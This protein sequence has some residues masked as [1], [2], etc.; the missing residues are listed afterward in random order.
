[1]AAAFNLT[2]QLNLKG[3]TNIG[4]ITSSIKQQLG[5]ITANVDLKINQSSIKNV[6]QLNAGLQQLNKTLSSTT[7][8]AAS[9]AQALTALG[10][11]VGSINIKNLPQQLTAS[12]NAINQIHTESNNAKKE[13]AQATTQMEEFGKQ[14]AL[15]VRRFAAFSIVTSS[16]Y[17]LSNSINKG[18][19]AFIE[20]DQ[21]FVKLQQVTGQSANG[22]KSLSQEITSLSVGLGVSSSAL[23]DVAST[24]AQAGL[25]AQD[26]EKALRAL[27]L[28][29]LAPSFD[30]MNETVEGSIA[31][32][33]QFGIDA[34][35]LEKALSSINTVAAKFAVE[36][37]DIITAIQRTGGVFATASK[38][39]SEGTDALNEFIA[40]F[41]SV[42]ATTR[43]SAETIATGLRTIF[44]R[45]QRGSTI[46]ALKEFGVNLQDAEGKFVGAY[47]AVELLSKGLNSLDP[48][49]VKFSKIIEELGGFR[50]IG[51][52]IPLIQ[53]FSV[54]QNALKVAQQGQGS[55]AK[56]AATAQ[57]SLANQI[58]KV[59]Q[60]FLALFREIGQ[61]Q[62]F[63]VMVKATL[64]L[65]S[66]L[67]K[68]AD[69]SKGLLP[70]LGV[71][72][73]FKGASAITQ[74]ASGFGQGLKPG[75]GKK[76]QEKPLFSQGGPVRAFASGGVVP[77][78]GDG[79][80]VPAMLTPGEFVIRKKAV[81]A[82]GAQNL[83]KMNKY[84]KGGPVTLERVSQFSS[85]KQIPSYINRYSKVLQ[86]QDEIEGEI[87][88]RTI[89][90]QE[91]EQYYE[92]NPHKQFS[93]YIQKR[94][95]VYNSRKKSTIKQAG[96][97]AF[98]D[99][100]GEYIS[101]KD[102]LSGY[103]KTKDPQ[104]PVDFVGGDDP[105]EVRFRQSIT[106]DETILAKRFRHG[107]RYST[108]KM[109]G[110]FT[111]KIDDRPPVDIG[112][113]IVYQV[114]PSYKKAMGFALGGK[115]QKFLKGGTVEETAQLENMSLQDAILAQIKEMG[116]IKGVKSL[117]GIPGGQRTLDSLLRAEV[118][119]KRDTLDPTALKAVNDALSNEEGKT[120]RRAQNINKSQKL[121]V[122][123][124]QPFDKSTEIP[125]DIPGFES[126]TIFIRGLSSKYADAVA[127]MREMVENTIEKFGADIQNTMIFGGNAPLALDF[128]ETLVHGADIFGPNGKPDIPSYDD[129]DKVAKALNGD[130]VKLTPLG[131]K[132]KD[133]VGFD[134][135]FINRIRVLTARPQSNAGL[136]SQKLNEL[137]IPLGADKITGVSGGNKGT[138][139]GL[140]E[141]LVD[142]N[143]KNINDAKKA[144]KSAVQ[145]AELR[146]LSEEE[147]AATGNANAEGAILEAALAKMGAVG[148]SVQNRAVDFENGLGM[149]AAQAFPG[150][151]PDWPTEV[152]RTL[153]SDNIGRAKEEFKRYYSENYGPWPQQEEA[154]GFDKA[155]MPVS[156]FS[157][158]GKA[159]RTVDYEAGV[160][161]SPFGGSISKRL[162]QYVYGLQKGT[163]LSDQEFNEIKKTADTYGY[164]EQEFKEY[165]AKR[166]QEK[167]NRSG[168]R[169]DPSELLRQLTPQSRTSTPKQ[170]ALA[171]QLKGEPDAGYRPLLTQAQ[172]I[173][174]SRSDLKNAMGYAAGGV[175]EPEQK[176][177]KQYGKISISE[178]GTMISAGY[179]KN[180]SRQGYATAYKM[181][182]NL[183]YVGLSSATNGY[184]PRLYDIL[185]EAATEKGAMLTSDRSAVSGDA[186]K[187]W[188]YY[189]KNR[190][191][192]KKTPL[193]P[194]DWT[195]NDAL[196]DPKLH[197]RE[198]TWPPATDPAWVL[199]SG[200]SKNPN[201]INDKDV[202]R[203]NA[204]LDSRA[205]MNS[206][207][208]AKRQGFASGG[209]VEDTVPA[210][211]TP[212]E[213]VVNKQAAQRIGYTKLHQL[214]HADKIAGFNKGGIVGGIQGYA[215]GGSVIVNRAIEDL[216]DL[217]GYIAKGMR[218]PSVSNPPKLVTRPD[219]PSRATLQVSDK[220]AETVKII[221]Q[222]LNNLGVNVSNVA[223]LMKIGGDISYKAMEKAIK[224]DIERMTITGASIEQITKA[225]TA[226]AAVREESSTRVKKTQTLEDSFRN[227]NIGQKLGSGGSQ[228]QIITEAA[229]AEKSIKAQKI[230]DIS[231]TLQMPG[232]TPE[233]VKKRAT[234]LATTP[235]EKAKTKEL[236]Y[237]SAAQK[238]TGVKKTDFQAAGISGEDIQKY[239]NESLRD[240]KTLAVMDKQLIASKMQE[241]QSSQ[242]YKAA[243]NA[244]QSRMLADVKKAAQEEVSIRREII[245]DLAR[246]KGEKGV[247]AGGFMDTRNSPIYQTIK[248]NM[249]KT[250]GQG[251]GMATAAGAV[252]GGLASSYGNTI[253]NSFY[254]T[255]T[256][257]GK[258]KAAKTGAVISGTGTIASTGLG[259]AAQSL[260]VDPSGI[261]AGVIAAGTGLVAFADYM[262][263]FTGAQQKAVKEVEKAL[264]ARE[265]NA[266]TASLDD[267]FK[268]FE[269]D[270]S[271][272]DFQ[273]A[274]NKEL[275]NAVMTQAKDTSANIDTAKQD[276]AYQNRSWGDLLN[277]N[278]KGSAQMDAKQLAEVNRAEAEKF[279]PIADKGYKQIQAEINSGASIEQIMSN[280]KL[281]GARRAIAMS[282]PEGISEYT[283]AKA[284]EEK[285]T[286]KPITVNRNKEIIDEI[287]ARKIAT[288][289][290]ILTAI[291]AK[292]VADALEAANLAGRKL[293]QSFQRMYDSI[294]QAIN[295][296]NF[297]IQQRKTSIDYSTG[298]LTGNITTPEFASKSVD[299]LN[300]PKTYSKKAFEEA[301]DVA[302]QS[303]P[304]ADAKMVK[305]SSILERDLVPAIEAELRKNLSTDAGLTVDKAAETAKKTGTEQVKALGLPK[306]MEDTIIN[307]LTSSID[308]KAK[309]KGI[310]QEFANGPKAA[311]D[312][313]IESIREESKSIIQDAGGGIEKSKSLLTNTQDYLNDF[314]KNLAKSSVL[315]KQHA[316]SLIKARNI[317]DDAK[318]NLREAL[319]GIGET[320]AE[321]K[322]RFDSEISDLTGGTTDPKAI[323]ANIENLQNRGKGLVEQIGNST[324]N[325]D[326]IKFREELDQTNNS[327]RDN[328][329]ALERLA[330]SSELAAKALGEVTKVR[331]LQKNR[332]EL[333]NK[334]LTQTPEEAKKLNDTFVRLQNNLRGGLNNATNSRE[335]RAAFS[336]AL[337][338]GSSIQGAYRA[339]NTVLAQQ[340]Q[341]TLS[342]FQD[343]NI[344]GAQKLEMKNQA[345]RQGK[346]LSDEQIEN[347][348]N[349]QEAQLKT[350][351]AIETGQINNPMVRADI[352]AT[353]NRTFDPAMKQATD[354]YTK[355]TGRQA[356][357]NTE[358]GRLALVNARLINS[359]SQLIEAIDGLTV[360]IRNA[361][362]F[363]AKVEGGKLGAAAAVAA[364]KGVSLEGVAPAGGNAPGTLYASTGALVNFQPKGTDTVPAMLTPG[365]FV[366]NR[367]ST[368]QYLPLLQAINKSKGGVVYLAEGS[369]KPVSVLNR[370]KSGYKSF[371][372]FFGAAE[373]G[374]EIASERASFSTPNKVRE[375]AVSAMDTA[376]YAMGT[377]GKGIPGWS[378]I[379]S[380]MDATTKTYEAL[381]DSEATASEKALK[382]GGAFNSGLSVT[383]DLAV[384]RAAMPAVTPA[385]AGVLAPKIAS[386]ASKF[387][388]PLGTVLTAGMGVQDALNDKRANAQDLTIAEKVLYGITT[389]SAGTGGDGF[390][391]D[392]AEY[393]TSN[394][395][396][397]ASMSLASSP[398]GTAGGLLGY[399]GTNTEN[400]QEQLEQGTSAA[401]AAASVAYLGP[402]ATTAAGAVGGAAVTAKVA[403]QTARLMEKNRAD[404][405]DIMKKE[406][407]LDTRRFNEQMAEVAGPNAQLN[408]MFSGKGRTY[409]R[410]GLVY[411]AEGS[412]EPVKREPVK[413]EPEERTIET[414]NEFPAEV[415]ADR[416]NPKGHFGIAAIGSFLAK[417]PEMGFGEMVD[418]IF[419]TPGQG[420]RQGE[421]A[422]SPPVAATQAPAKQE[423]Q[424]EA[425][426]S[427]AGMLQIDLSKSDTSVSMPP[428]VQSQSGVAPV[429][430]PQMIIPSVETQAPAKTQA[431]TSAVVPKGA[432]DLLQDQY[433]SGVFNSPLGET[434]AKNSGE[435]ARQDLAK[436]GALNGSFIEEASLAM[437]GEQ[438]KLQQMTQERMS[439]SQFG[440]GRRGFKNRRDMMSYQYGMRNYG[441]PMTPDEVAYDTQQGQLARLNPEARKRMT[442]SLAS[443]GKL[444]QPGSELQ[445]QVVKTQQMQQ[446]MA[447][448]SATQEMEKL[449]GTPSSGSAELANSLINMANGEQQKASSFGRK[450]S[451]R[452]DSLTRLRDM[453]SEKFDEQKA[454]ELAGL[455]VMRQSAR[456]AS[457]PGL[458]K[459]QQDNR[460]RSRRMSLMGMSPAERDAKDQEDRT[461]GKLTY[462]NKSRNDIYKELRDKKNPPKEELAQAEPAATNAAQA[463]Q[464]ALEQKA[465]QNATKSITDPAKEKPVVAQAQDTAK[466]EQVV[467]QSSDSL[468]LPE[469]A[470]FSPVAK[471]LS[472][473]NEELRQAALSSAAEQE[474]QAT[475]TAKAAA[476]EQERQAAN[477]E[478]RTKAV[479]AYN[480]QMAERNKT[481]IY[482]ANKELDKLR[483]QDGKSG[484]FGKYDHSEKIAELEAKVRNNFMDTDD[485][486]T[487]ATLSTME[488]DAKKSKDNP[489]KLIADAR[490][491]THRDQE[492]KQLADAQ[493]KAQTQAAEDSKMWV[494]SSNPLV[495][496]L[497]YLGGVGQATGDMAYGAA[498][499]VAGTAVAGAGLI[500][501]GID[502]V[503]TSKEEARAAMLDEKIKAKQKENTQFLGVDLATAQ[504]GVAYKGPTAAQAFTQV[505]AEAVAQGAY[506]AVEG[507]QAVAGQGPHQTGEKSWLHQGDDKRVE[508]AG[509]YGG[510]TRAAQNIG[511]VSSQ[512]AV[513]L[514]GAGPGTA[515][516]GALGTTARVLSKIDDAAMMPLKLLGKGAGKVTSA[517]GNTRLGGQ[518][519]SM[520]RRAGSAIMDTPLVRGTRTV[521]GG[522]TDTVK[523]FD[524]RLSKI[525]RDFIKKNMDAA[526]GVRS[527][528]DEYFDAARQT[529]ARGKLS[530]EA[531]MKYHSTEIGAKANQMIGTDT[532]RMN[533]YGRLTGGDATQASGMLS[534]RAT[535]LADL[536]AARAAGTK[537]AA[538]TA[539]VEGR[540]TAD[541]FKQLDAQ[542][543]ADQVAYGN[544][545][546][547]QARRNDPSR[548]A[549]RDRMRAEGLATQKRVQRGLKRQEQ[550]ATMTPEQ[551]AYERTKR[552]GLERGVDIDLPRR[553][554]AQMRKTDE[555]WLRIEIVKEDDKAKGLFTQHSYGRG[556]SAQA[557]KA[558]DRLRR[559]ASSRGVNAD[560]ARAGSP[561]SFGRLQDAQ[562][563][564][565]QAAQVADMRRTFGIDPQ[566]GRYIDR[567]RVSTPTAGTAD[568]WRP[569]W[570]EPFRSGPSSPTSRVMGVMD[571]QPKT[572]AQ[573][574]LATTKK[575]AGDIFGTL[576]PEQQAAQRVI[577][578]QLELTAKG[579][580]PNTG[581]KYGAVSPKAPA[582]VPAPDRLGGR[583]YTMTA[584]TFV[585]EDNLVAAAQNAKKSQAAAKATSS[586][587][588]PHFM[589]K[590][591]IITQVAAAKKANPHAQTIGGPIKIAPPRGSSGATGLTKTQ[592]Q[593]MEYT[594]KMPGN[595]R[596]AFEALAQSASSPEAQ[597]KLLDDLIAHAARTNLEWI[598]NTITAPQMI[599]DRAKK[600]SLA[601]GKRANGL[602][603]YGGKGKP[604]QIIVGNAGTTGEFGVGVHESAHFLQHMSGNVG[605]KK[606]G[607]LI[608]GMQKATG[609]D[610]DSFLQTDYS[611][612]S[613]GITGYTANDIR[614]NPH[615]LLTVLQQARVDPRS[616]KAFKSSSKAQQLLSYMM[617]AHGYND[618]GIVYAANGALMSAMSKGTDTVP[619]MLTPGEFVMN[620]E[621]T[622][623]NLPLLKAI[624]S[625]NYEHGGLIKYMAQGGVV[626]PQYKAAGGEAMQQY[627]S[628]SNNS[629]NKNHSEDSRLERIEKSMDKFIGIATTFERA[630]ESMGNN[631]NQFSQ[632]VTT[633][634]TQMSHVLSATV[635]GSI[636]NS[637]GANTQI[638]NSRHEA[639]IAVDNNNQR[640]DRASEGSFSRSDPTIMRGT[641][642]AGSSHA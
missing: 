594:R 222:E 40:V 378:T 295:K 490:V 361:R 436:T 128:D 544:Y 299:V 80:T 325:D 187:V 451:M 620:R 639:Q 574:K 185:M 293:A 206:F 432:L 17:A 642:G 394:S 510:L 506:T 423:A 139:M 164:N 226:L 495:S 530:P 318:M 406:E 42:R 96:G 253:A 118:I 617:Q 573:V 250:F 415:A 500:A 428:V 623:Q 386:T 35:G 629:S 442:D 177:E 419:G 538:I 213:F 91:I 484:W 625:G 294:D 385:A 410:G 522:V 546:A 160:G 475:Q 427:S 374:S 491:K 271:N 478:A 354:E 367:E 331:D 485:A 192:V 634:P 298:A 641:P 387:T 190:G 227:S 287:A 505:G 85:G 116:G 26:T 520:A 28:S 109:L 203:Q 598:D 552:R 321:A 282:T 340:R 585:P 151:A 314:S 5:T 275:S 119:K 534:D 33:R 480:A 202:I 472:A 273:E 612:I 141:R 93:D 252:V 414:A 488:V 519:A 444:L 149:A 517:L 489:Y 52:V 511:Y 254:N 636:S 467:Q 446:T 375:F 276:Y 550:F 215:S 207:F 36:A 590:D 43:E 69:A 272:I 631:V 370:V 281:G 216:E 441:V 578:R 593:V 90:R 89:G 264:R 547:A 147:R 557:D 209:S 302:T 305:G 30:S 86:N 556:A 380:A 365:E 122:V 496:G 377:A 535:R 587:T 317:I 121:A 265:I 55:L 553:Q 72:L 54:A 606:Q 143:I 232:A 169:S 74:F 579:I 25:N 601:P 56:D 633:M 431:Q 602:I 269:I 193:K 621:S 501:Q 176:Q 300:N 235:E 333:V 248:R 369:Q 127:G 157:K 350:Q 179:L 589:D 181:R 355:T 482:E 477:E 412:K 307:Q 62:G 351:M 525:E 125:F 457:D 130:K 44:T 88:R 622:Q 126:S 210:L 201:L 580:D 137:G 347:I 454:K 434:V 531:A 600:M 372:S 95:S 94:T 615:E 221:S 310:Q 565:R 334:L 443:S 440:P 626:T 171:E 403:G 163:G 418:S 603:K 110:K 313:F 508:M 166:I 297:N 32:M 180:D 148:G 77:G 24:L 12:S 567:P 401:R 285:A 135:S 461:S 262:T 570:N 87:D 413:R 8:T 608:A 533:R 289:A 136:L 384:A 48:R 561:G 174:Q 613:K 605:A 167:K 211:L 41:T 112:R 591:A 21:Q 408:P 439:S 73:A 388:G 462:V 417:N 497:G 618:G 627:T 31:L 111:P 200:Y 257:E 240:R 616:R 339:G 592:R 640:M 424:K 319:T 195:R 450:E 449:G 247:G 512:A 371:K 379:S 266:A 134:S 528:G 27:A 29:S 15:A 146:K 562:D 162:G 188:E 68:V 301:L 411:L 51:K 156:R 153:S 560:T 291:K 493:T 239:V 345:A 104:A 311:T 470:S 395:G 524:P 152:K 476:K 120:I 469:P 97:Y 571:N 568:Q 515:G 513:A 540:R 551:K 34:G 274:L 486:A 208:A 277:L 154:F 596:A 630:S 373:E 249:P 619:A 405:L 260:A 199:Q 586:T 532:A 251:I 186:K 22:L 327:I 107:I 529:Y 507:V 445:S 197:G 435:L 348:F 123:G 581:L 363:D 263:D 256:D 526:Y 599:A 430:M 241:L 400:V 67:I 468:I 60:E 433:S 117:L 57:L 452:R 145:Y 604:A 245:N 100:I 632:A 218:A 402:L 184:G 124:L 628:S 383:K 50:Q 463:Q 349:Q 231:S 420:M 453:G 255:S 438:D 175:A 172:R 223:E 537:D 588:V 332:S 229:K 572:A 503:T 364:G 6:A 261:S 474:R 189:F 368:Q 99:F 9:A 236:A 11:A 437:K 399:G 595:Q 224:K 425:A 555:E 326:I 357:A 582:P 609:F 47:K 133:I 283:A 103:R 338:S 198:E 514:A 337:R 448:M 84:A 323:S 356:D 92:S 429:Q 138:A 114:D 279:A 597:Q 309:D 471:S 499:V 343:P 204:K 246:T 382:L 81:Q 237:L 502:A 230:K 549:R 577:D 498:N 624:N 390:T 45:I 481:K 1:M 575:P 473:S 131:E 78:S 336:Q 635:N 228:Q 536:K 610:M 316:D 558:A 284:A 170:L 61:S 233:E 183:Y 398:L 330:N 212:G 422:I 219:T 238:V 564:Q 521:I 278:F 344:R 155:G 366:I 359:N 584:G 554:Q 63:Q 518:A 217:M 140:A 108:A 304:A 516:N 76:G 583:N 404:S 312:K 527:S 13:L 409:S 393:L 19:E 353:K 303:L 360:E 426:A 447:Q 376:D 106:P 65:A 397:V 487:L 178:D 288:Q 456:F 142:D 70:L 23:T 38:G 161:P 270:M 3:P 392:A 296:N 566:T 389:G 466:T 479:A 220:T 165:L 335:A 381:T 492:N 158:G 2:A 132:I 458:E 286:G 341:E 258:L 543:A 242:T 548:I 267:A 75:A 66:A 182:D 150:I 559:R 459:R 416:E 194:S 168:L 292:Q 391:K 71:M 115:I 102:G 539:R 98:E 315:L 280:D 173:A 101:K 328:R 576:T 464:K 290:E 14:S 82:I 105:I 306:E 59:R 259:M 191:D 46:D 396:K 83:H 523:S 7:T 509:E 611:T 563:Q 39:V 320:F 16:I 308:A 58:Q 268:K 144:G 483:Q 638:V 205:V 342:M 129:L 18:I 465:V 569:Q 10:Q 4:A 214:N 113:S 494:E 542:D 159:S 545:T 407:Q 358:I 421:M 352:E 614:T 324:N 346:T 460:D 79:D 362:G 637:T 504:A 329:E 49:D 64:S 244:E 225:E 196:I 541:F 455:D 322:T 20:Y 607:E 243:S 234:E 53:Q 37:S